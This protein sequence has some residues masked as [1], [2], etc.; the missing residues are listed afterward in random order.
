M[1][2]IKSHLP[3]LILIAL[4]LHGCSNSSSPLPSGSI[5]GEYIYRRQNETF[6]QIEPATLI[7][8]LAYPWEEDKPGAHPKITKYFFRCKGCLLNPVH[9]LKKGNDVVPYYDC[10]GMQ[11]H[12]L[13]LRDQNEFIFP[14]LIDLLNYVQEKTG[15]QVVITCGHCCPDHNSYLDPSPANQASKHMLG[16]EVDFYVRGM[17]QSPAEVINLILS[18]YREQEKYRGMKEYLEF[19]RYE[20]EDRKVSIPPWYNKEIYVKVYKK[21]EGRDFDNGHSY[22]YVSIQV[23]YDWDRNEPVNYTWDKAF[24]NFYRL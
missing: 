12:S 20:K 17:E 2:M 9:V 14:I 11:R 1:I 5:K 23:R 10:G 8:R 22:P 6:A 16:A 24:R 3:G 4:A 18:Y 7:P 15:K 13:P 19:K 21:E